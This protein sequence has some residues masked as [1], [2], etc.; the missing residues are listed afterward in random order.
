MLSLLIATL[1]ALQL[2]SP[3][4]AAAYT[5][6]L[7]QIRTEYAE[8]PVVLAETRSGVACMPHCGAELRE[9]G[10]SKPV[11]S[12]S[13][14]PEDHS[15]GVVRVLREHDL[16][17]ATCAVRQASFGCAD[18]PDHLFVGLGAL[19]ERPRRGPPPVEGAFWLKAA[20]LVPGTCA[21]T[22]GQGRN[23]PEAV[24]W[25]F[26]VSPAGTD[27]EWRVVRRLPAFAI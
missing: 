27:G 7:R 24:G 1:G 2:S 6:V 20:I 3:D 5:A 9:P 11:V 15:P 4:T 18:H 26:L 25:W 12:A 21:S 17:Q 10:Q 23:V 19:E 22:P 16:V 8:L 13:A 14:P